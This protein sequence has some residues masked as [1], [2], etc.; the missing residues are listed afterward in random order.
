VILGRTLPDARTHI[1][2]DAGH[3]IYRFKRDEFRSMVLDF[4]REC[5]LPVGAPGRA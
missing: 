1:F 2:Q 4:A 5:G 3:G